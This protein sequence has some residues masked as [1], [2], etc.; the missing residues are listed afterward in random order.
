[1]RCKLVYSNFL[2]SRTLERLKHPFA[3]I[4]IKIEKDVFLYLAKASDKQFIIACAKL[5]EKWKLF[6]Q[7][8]VITRF[9]LVDSDLK[10]TPDFER[11]K[12]CSVSFFVQYL[13]GNWPWYEGEVNL[14]SLSDLF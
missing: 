2:Q 10:L 4:S 3:E 6:S 1:M 8:I 12:R 13:S 9:I 5:K 7:L 14:F 11:F